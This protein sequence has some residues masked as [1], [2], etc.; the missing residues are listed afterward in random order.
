MSVENNPKE[1]R[2]RQRFQNYEKAFIQL[3]DAVSQLDQLSTLEKEG[4]VQRFEYTFELGWKTLKDFFE[5]KNVEVKFTRDVIKESFKTELLDDG[6]IWLEMLE[7]RNLMSHTYDEV[8]F[9][10]VLND[11]E[12]RYFDQLKKIY[13]LFKSQ[14]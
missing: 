8:I 1:I 12:S 6:E 7:K 11:I 9:R 2:W 5:S 4:L 10:S 14:L 13:V 3:S